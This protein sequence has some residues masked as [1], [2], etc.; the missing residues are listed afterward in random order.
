MS[1][2][3]EDYE[4]LAQQQADI[5]VTHEAPSNHPH[6]FIEIDQLA[7]AMGAKLI[8]HGHH[9]RDYQTALPSGIR[10]IGVGLAG[11]ATEDGKILLPDRRRAQETTE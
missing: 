9:H 2:W 8:V 6:G 7:E 10:V 1:I 5:L 3:P 11:V 4:R